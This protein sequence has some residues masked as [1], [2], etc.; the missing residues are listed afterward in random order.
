[1][2]LRRIAFDR[3]QSG[4]TTSMSKEAVELMSEFDR[5]KQLEDRTSKIEKIY[6]SRVPIAEAKY[7]DLSAHAYANHA[8][9]CTQPGRILETV[10]TC[11][12]FRQK[13]NG[14]MKN[15]CN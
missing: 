9:V 14:V 5:L 10:K 3:N 15:V 13:W 12:L 6:K 11:D 4:R 1:M 7:E 8:C 2:D